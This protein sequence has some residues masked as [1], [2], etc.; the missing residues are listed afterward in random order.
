[1]SNGVE[2]TQ[3]QTVSTSESSNFK[4]YKMEQGKKWR[5]FLAAIVCKRKIKNK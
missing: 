3:Y 4:K 1:M 2:L 5:Q